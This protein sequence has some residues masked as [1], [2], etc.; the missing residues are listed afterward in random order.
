MSEI[1]GVVTP[2]VDM[3]VGA[4]S[5]VQSV[6]HIAFETG[7]SPALCIIPWGISNA[8]RGLPDGSTETMQKPFYLSSSD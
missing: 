1:V 7:C 5:S 8:T 6:V 2:R 4:V 3:V